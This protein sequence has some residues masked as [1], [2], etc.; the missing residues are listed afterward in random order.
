MKSKVPHV[1][2]VAGFFGALMLPISYAVIDDARAAEQNRLIREAVSR[3][4]TLPLE[5]AG[6]VEFR[7]DRGAFVVRTSFRRGFERGPDRGVKVLEVLKD[8]EPVAATPRHQFLSASRWVGR[9]TSEIDL[10][11]KNYR[12]I[13]R[14]TDR[15]AGRDCVRF[16]FAGRHGRRPLHSLW[17]DPAERIVVKRSVENGPRGMTAEFESVAVLSETGPAR[18]ER[19]RRRPPADSFPGHRAPFLPIEA[20]APRPDVGFEIVERPYLPNGFERRTFGVVHVKLREP[21]RYE[22][23]AVLSVYTDGLQTFSVVQM[24]TED[25]EALANMVR[26]LKGTPIPDVLRRMSRGSVSGEMTREGWMAKV[27]RNG[28]TLVAAGQIDQ[29]EIATLMSRFL[30]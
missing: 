21:L 20:G 14:G 29:D 10:V 22:T 30:Y 18:P 8:G 23:R 11:L 28:T 3:S 2:A 24:R 12:P 15:V 25:F 16:D 4:A 13:H 9:F 19:P 6:R 26:G 7:G 5:G 1:L 17:I 27:E